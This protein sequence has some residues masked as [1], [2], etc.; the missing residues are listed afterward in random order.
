MLYGSLPEQFLDS[1]S[2]LRQGNKDTLVTRLRKAM[3]RLQSTVEHHAKKTT[4]VFKNMK[5]ASH[6]LVRHDASA[7]ALHLPYDGPFEVLNRSNKTYKLRIRGKAVNISVD[8]LKP[9]YILDDE[10]PTTKIPKA[11]S[12]ATSKTTR[13]GRTI[14]QP[15]RFTPK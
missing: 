13:T 6:V 15:V 11:D 9:A 7:G 2:L 10:T 5:T 3:I 8:R 4:F 12:E 14:R 1:S